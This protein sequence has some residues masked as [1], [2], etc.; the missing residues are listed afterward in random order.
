MTP[1]IVSVLMPCKGRPE[2]TVALIPRLYQTAGAVSWELICIVDA[3][4]V[5]AQALRDLNAEARALGRP[6]AAIIELPERQGYWKALAH[7][8]R[9]ARGRI[10][11][12]IAN[13]VLPGLGWL[14]RATAT[15]DRLYPDG[16]GVVGWNDGLLFDGHTGHI[17]IGRE[18]AASWYG[19]A[20]WP[21]W[22]DHLYGDTEICTRAIADARYAVDLRAVLYH[23][24]PVIGRSLDEIY[25]FS[26]NR[27]NEDARIF[28]QRRALQWP[29]TP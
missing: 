4:P 9:Q 17:L 10:L 20:H 28:E 5:V 25:R 29:T 21:T 8:T 26:H 22:Y 18:L 14:R 19:A 27:Q 11:A 24:H 23:N 16:R 13:D 1:P 12:N 15:F 7:G 3:D 2:Q 6:Q